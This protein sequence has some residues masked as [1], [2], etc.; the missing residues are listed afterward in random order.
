MLACSAPT[1]RAVT[2]R[3][4]S[5]SRRTAATDSTMR[6]HSAAGSPTGSWSRSTGTAVSRRT[7]PI[8]IPGEAGRGPLTDAARAGAG[9]SAASS[10]VSSNRRAARVSR[11]STASC[12]CG[13]EART[14]T[15]C[16]RRAASVATRLRLPAGTGAPP[17][18]RLRSWTDASSARTSLTSRAAGRA[19][20]PWGFST[21]KTPTTSSAPT[22]PASGCGAFRRR[23]QVPRLAHERV[24]RLGRDLRPAGSAGRRDGGDDEALDEGGRRERHAVADRRVLRAG[25]APARR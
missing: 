24:A 18:V 25:R 11:C 7:G 8:A 22:S 12:A 6:R 19:C 5:M 21:E 15:S 20:R 14:S 9:G 3:T 17:V 13:P 4:C 1:S 2:T 10:T 23:R 16:P